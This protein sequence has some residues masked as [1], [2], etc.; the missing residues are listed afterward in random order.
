MQ[1]QPSNPRDGSR[2]QSEASRRANLLVRQA[3]TVKPIT[4]REVDVKPLTVN[5]G[6]QSD[7]KDDSED[8]SDSDASTDSEIPV[9]VLPS[10]WMR[11]EGSSSAPS[12]ELGEMQ[13]AARKASRGKMDLA[14]Q[15]A[16]QYWH[17][18]DF[19][20][21]CTMGDVLCISPRV[22]EQQLPT[23][24]GFHAAF[25]A[26]VLLDCA[27]AI[28]EGTVLSDALRRVLTDQEEK[29]QRAIVQPVQWM[30]GSSKT[31]SDAQVRS[32]LGS[33]MSHERVR[34]VL[35]EHERRRAKTGGGANGRTPRVHVV[36]KPPASRAEE[37]EVVASIARGISV[38]GGLA[39][40]AG[41]GQHWVA[42]AAAVASRPQGATVLLVA[43]SGGNKPYLAGMPRRELSQ[44]AVDHS[45]QIYADAWER[46]RKLMTEA[47]AAAAA[48][49]LQTR[50]L[51]IEARRAQEHHGVRAKGLEPPPIEGRDESDDLLRDWERH[52]PAWWPAESR[53]LCLGVD[54][55]HRPKTIRFAMAE[56]EVAD[57]EVH[58]RT[59]QTA[60]VK[61]VHGGEVIT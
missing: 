16:S 43:D 6:A 8:E 60:L 27:R 7:S 12:D 18:D 44:L 21:A 20:S 56:L 55:T 35:A 3:S 11:T 38:D 25:N 9:P 23:T 36:S 50:A 24:C 52:I 30:S 10:H 48:E 37:E 32:F 54:A 58:L 22:S 46:Q 17:P 49:R 47:K 42:I 51:V 61:L 45:F 33:P 4:V 39:M 1:R 53:D 34:L 40:V 31:L 26:L 14:A 57:A 2:R 15:M 59:V 5:E 19:T 29:W 41:C 13:L 28:A